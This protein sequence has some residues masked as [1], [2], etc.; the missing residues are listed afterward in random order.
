M[1][2]KNLIK[3]SAPVGVKIISILYYIGAVA[4][5][6][7]IL[8]VAFWKEFLSQI[9]SIDLL[10]P[11]FL[12]VIIIAGLLMAVLDFFV[13]RGLWKGQNWARIVAI[14]FSALGLIG[15]IVSLVQGSI[16]S[17]IISLVIDGVIGGYLLFAKEV[18]RFFR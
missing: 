12:V 9:P 17:G 11:S 18:K 4:S 7:L 15:A 2:K 14:V 3:K 1:E 5:I 8:L 13:A 10:G 16:G 6:L